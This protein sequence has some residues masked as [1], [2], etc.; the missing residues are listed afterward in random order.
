MLR[1]QGS[2]KFHGEVNEV[3]CDLSHGLPFLLVSAIEDQNGME[4]SIADMTEDRNGEVVLITKL[5]KFPNGFRNLRH[6]DTKIFDQGD[7]LRSPSYFRKGGDEA[8][9]T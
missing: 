7:Q 3:L 4:V 9:A 2:F 8:L 5:L 6:R 1:C